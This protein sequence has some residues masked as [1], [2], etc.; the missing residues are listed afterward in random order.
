[1]NSLPPEL[2]RMVLEHVATS[3]MLEARLVSRFWSQVATEVAS[4]HIVFDLDRLQSMVQYLNAGNSMQ[5]VIKMLE[6]TIILFDTSDISATRQANKLTEEFH[7]V[8]DLFPFLANVSKLDLNVKM[9]ESYGIFMRH[10]SFLDDRHLATVYDLVHLPHLRVVELHVISEELRLI[11][12]HFAPSLQEIHIHERL[13]TSDLQLVMLFLRDLPQLHA[14]EIDCITSDR[15]DGQPLRPFIYESLGSKCPCL[16]IKRLHLRVQYERRN[17]ELHNVIDLMYFLLHLARNV[18]DLALRLARHRRESGKYALTPLDR[19]RLPS[20]VVCPRNLWINAM[21]FSHA[22]SLDDDSSSPS[23][24]RAG[25]GTQKLE[26]LTLGPNFLPLLPLLPLEGLKS[27]CIDN[28]AIAS[29]RAP[30]VK[31]SLSLN[32]PQLEHLRLDYLRVQFPLLERPFPHIK[33]LH[34]HSC[35]LRS[36][37]TLELLLLQ[38]PTLK[39]VFMSFGKFD[40]WYSIPLVKP[41]NPWTDVLLFLCATACAKPFQWHSLP[42]LANAITI[43]CYYHQAHV[44]IA[45]QD[46]R[47]A[48]GSSVKIWLKH[49]NDTVVRPFPDNDL[50]VLLQRLQ[51]HKNQLINNEPLQ[52]F[53]SSPLVDDAFSY[54]CVLQH[55]DVYVC[56][57]FTEFT[58]NSM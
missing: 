33:S 54:L 1:M 15:V 49:A 8:Q 38:L 37:N 14:L 48:K 40:T 16:S 53:A 12:P 9:E 41:D 5:L 26:S 28:Q 2:V 7:V 52:H 17:Y 58:I 23:I 20:N 44:C 35:C 3:D 25:D 42:I 51:N 50:P 29:Y 31:E 45:L 55:A 22:P 19:A 32:L 27:L 47:H 10:S 13:E 11:T 56:T 30:S 46:L 6:V 43:K 34:L 4:D 18:D 24:F 21:K 36:L 57:S 39:S